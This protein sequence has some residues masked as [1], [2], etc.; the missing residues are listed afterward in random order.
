[1]NNCIDCKTEISTK[2]TYC[3]DCKILRRRA[4][5]LVKY[6]KSKTP[7]STCGTLKKTNAKTCQTCRIVETRHK[8]ENMT[9]N[10]MVN[11]RTN[12]RTSVTNRYTDI[13]MM[14]RN[15]NIALG[16]SCMRCGYSLHVEIAHI[17]AISEFDGETLI[18]TINHPSNLLILCRNC[19]H[20]FDAKLI[21]LSDIMGRA[22]TAPALPKL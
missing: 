12:N 21:D 9:L 13:R 14:A 11:R 4:R 15:S 8:L 3:T 2:R 1:M 16:S 5:D 7:C 20:E 10:E 22:G 18:K 6:Y 17:K 19:H